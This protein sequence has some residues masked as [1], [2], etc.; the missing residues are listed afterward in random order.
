MGGCCGTIASSLSDC[1]G[2]EDGMVIVVGWVAAVVPLLSPC[3]T[4]L[5]LGGCV[6]RRW[7][8]FCS[9]ITV[10]YC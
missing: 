3:P 7:V 1:H 4:V 9:V 5:E 2:T 10:T 8:G 6:I